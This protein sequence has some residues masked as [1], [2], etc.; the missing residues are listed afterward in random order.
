MNKQ[1]IKKV[2]P[3]I[4]VPALIMFCPAPEGLSPMAWKLFAIYVGAILGLVF[5]PFPEPV[6]MLSAILKMRCQ[7]IQI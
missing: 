7:A 5:Q 4:L 6:I 3:V 1:F 2:L